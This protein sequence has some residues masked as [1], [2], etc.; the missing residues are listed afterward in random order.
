MTDAIQG[1]ARVETQDG[2]RL[3]DLHYEYDRAKAELARAEERFKTIADGIKAE[4]SAIGATK[5]VLTGTDGAKPLRLA[6]VEQWRVDSTKLKSEQPVIYAAY[7]KKSGH[8]KLEALKGS[9][10]E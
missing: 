8:W 2:T 3:R 9:E 4:L 10:E 1:P 6:W 7:A 5:V